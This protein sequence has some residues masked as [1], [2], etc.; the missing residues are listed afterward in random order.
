MGKSNLLKKIIVPICLI[1]VTAIVFSACSGMPDNGADNDGNY[2]YD[3]DLAGGDNYSEIVENAFVKVTDDNR[4]SNIS[5]TVNTA[6]YTQIQNYVDCDMTIPRNAAKIEEMINYFSYDYNAPKDGETFGFSAA[7]NDTPWNAETKL[8]TLGIGTK[9]IKAKEQSHNIVFLI[10]VS[11][12]MSGELRL[13][14]VKKTICKITDEILGDDDVVSIV[15]YASGVRTVLEGV[16]GSQK[17][18]IKNAVNSLSAGGST[19]GASGID[20]AYQVAFSYQ[21]ETNNSRII[22]ATDGDFNVGASTASELKKLMTEN[23]KRGV[24]VSALGYGMGNLSDVNMQEIVASG[25]GT[26]AFINNEDEAYSL[27]GTDRAD[28]ILTI[29]AE[30]AKSQIEFNPETVDSFRL[31]GYENKQLSNDEWKDKNTPAGAISGGSQVTAVYEI[32]LK[33]TS[34]LDLKDDSYA[35]LKTKYY[36]PGKTND[37]KQ[38]QFVV[39]ASY[40]NAADGHDAHIKKND[41]DFISAIIETGLLIRGSEYRG[42][43][44]LDAVVGRLNN[45]IINEDYAFRNG[46]KSL[47]QKLKNNSALISSGNKNMYLENKDN[48][49]ND[50]YFQ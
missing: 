44:N 24:Y 48:N 15:T 3:Y 2:Y 14:L 31:I 9:E 6:A 5:L 16:K 8:L 17:S 22:I 13:G 47:V 26:Y 50:F 23:R 32:K 36:N 30:E 19:A 39:G 27:F 41:F 7:L 25:Q 1:V 40:L 33:D 37:E 43:A 45:S 34:A 21:T 49:D 4:T 28:T 35:V 46:F 12:S 38:S 11:G 42:T 18:K 10:D 20:M 29:A